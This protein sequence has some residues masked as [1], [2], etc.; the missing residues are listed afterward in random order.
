MG[1]KTPRTAAILGLALA[2][3]A[4]ILF[5]PGAAWAAQANTGM[6]WE[7]P[8]E[9]LMN[10]VKGPIAYAV[11]LMGIVVAGATLVFGG[12]INEF[13]RRFIMLILVV[14]LISLAGNVL[15]NVF[16]VGA[17]IG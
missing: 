9:R 6:P 7:Q 15:T 4:V 13:V 14:S 17:V 1:S 10:S 2:V 3:G 5:E 11:S 8:L 12:E 16:G